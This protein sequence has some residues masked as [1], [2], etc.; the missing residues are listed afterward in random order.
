MGPTVADSVAGINDRM[1]DRPTSPARRSMSTAEVD[2]IIRVF[3]REDVKWRKIPGGGRAC[4]GLR[5]RS[6]YALRCDI[7][8]LS[9]GTP[10]LHPLFDVVV[11]RPYRRLGPVADV[12]LAKQ[13]LHV[14]L[15]RRLSDAQV[16]GNMLVGVAIEQATQNLTFPLR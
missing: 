16:D 6:C 10:S 5:L 2:A 13:A 9:R 4:L 15:Y 12:D 14:D 11:H 8:L 7:D 3:L 1:E